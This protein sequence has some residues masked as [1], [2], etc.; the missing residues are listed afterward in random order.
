MWAVT[1]RLLAFK[2]T[3]ETVPV[4]APVSRPQSKAAAFHNAREIDSHRRTGGHRIRPSCTIGGTGVAQGL[5]HDIGLQWSYQPRWGKR[6]RLLVISPG[7]GFQ[8]CVRNIID[9]DLKTG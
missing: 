2:G 1:S 4:A 7:D 8:D 6:D 3:D 5:A 9:A